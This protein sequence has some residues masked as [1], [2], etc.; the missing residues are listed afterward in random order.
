MHLMT[1]ARMGI[2]KF[3]IADADHFEAGNVNRQFGATI[4][5]FVR[6][7][8]EVLAESAKGFDP[9]A[10]PEFITELA[11]SANVDYLLEGVDLIVDAAPFEAP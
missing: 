5:K 4:G 11:T 1:L 9:E 8:A 3:R 10:E 7:K 2:G 6:P